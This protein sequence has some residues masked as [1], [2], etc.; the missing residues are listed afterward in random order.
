MH[1]SLRRARLTMVAAV[2]AVIGILGGAIFAS[3][4]EALPRTMLSDATVWHYADD[5]TDPASGR[6][7][8]LS[9]TR[10]DFDDSAW[11]TGSGGF[12]ATGGSATP[13][14]GPEFPVTTVLREQ[15]ASG[16]DTPAPAFRFRAKVMLTGEQLADL[17]SLRGTIV[18]DDAVQVYVNGTLVAGLVAE[19]AAEAHDDQVSRTAPEGTGHP[20]TSTFTVPVSAL[21]IGGNVIAV[22]LYQY[23]T[24]ASDIYLDVPSL[25]PA[26]S[27]AP[28]DI[29][30]LVLGVGADERQRSL[31][32][33]TSLDTEQIVQIAPAAAMRGRVFPEAVAWSVTATGERTID[34]QFRRSA[35]LSGLAENTRYV[36][37]VGSDGDWSPAYSFRTRAFD[38]GYTFLFL[39][40]PQ[41][42]SSGNAQRDSEGW[43]ATLDAAMAAY[44]D[45]EF[46]LT[47]G[48]H[49][50]AAD[51]EEEYAA[52]L[53]PLELREVPFV[54]TIGNHDVDSSAFMEHF[55]LPGLEEP[56]AEAGAPPVSGG[57]YWFSYK[58]VLF[59]VVD[60]NL[61]DTSSNIDFVRRVADEHGGEATWTILSFHHS[62]YSAGPH[63]DDPW[64]VADRALL[65]TAISDAGVDLVLQGHDH[66][67]ARSFLM[68]DGE[69][70]DVE[71]EPGAA[72]V[73]AGP[74]DVL[75]VTAD[76]ASGSKYYGLGSGDAGYLS[77]S[78]QERVR[79]YTV[80]ELSPSRLTVRTLRSEALDE[81]H[82]I[83]SVVDEVTV[84]R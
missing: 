81:E 28:V 37:R 11:R 25:V 36:Y 7:D 4:V 21:R 56:P 12:G 54:P 30:D 29:S 10:A 75:Y 24:S 77:V 46:L 22:A 38:G 49:V 3:T 40:D 69:K 44:P 57:N 45:A 18:Y 16:S 34:G 15:E 51:N 83:N 79:N 80:V 5:S 6:Q 76:S 59:I 82:G 50:D 63:A 60:S 62:I 31:T 35:T 48:D 20:S 14:L 53:A 26:A 8:G 71:E 19:R 32:W 41:I 43:A 39:G 61:A 9:W 13:D 78:N 52:L 72:S 68:H 1:V 27:P 23:D 47:S 58:E 33:Y 67:Y 2:L 73:D 17:G 84:R 70:A 74:G 42:G 55:T 64:I 65:P 66:S